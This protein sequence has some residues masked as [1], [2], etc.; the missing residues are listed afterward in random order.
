MKFELAF[1]TS[2][3]A[4]TSAG[5]IL[6]RQNLP[7]GFLNYV[8]QIEKVAKPMVPS[9][10]INAEPR[11]RSSATRKQIRFGPFTLPPTKVNT[12]YQTPHNYV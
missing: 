2:F 1:F 12:P 4:F 11:I 6:Q 5:T 10:I 7:D 8:P 3:V 9:K